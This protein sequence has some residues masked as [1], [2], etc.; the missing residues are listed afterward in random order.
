MAFRVHRTRNESRCRLTRLFSKYLQFLSN[1]PRH[2]QVFKNSER[3]NN[4]KLTLRK[5]VGKLVCVARYVYILTWQV[6]KS[7]VMCKWNEFF[8]KKC[9]SYLP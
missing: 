5:I 2:G 7:S 1:Y 9:R 4:I 6:I 3:Y 8:P